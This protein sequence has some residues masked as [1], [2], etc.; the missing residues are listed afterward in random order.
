MTSG[1]CSRTRE[2]DSGASILPQPAPRRCIALSQSSFVLSVFRYARIVV[3]CAFGSFRSSNSWRR[4]PSP[5]VSV[6]GCAFARSAAAAPAL[7][8][9]RSTNCC[10]NFFVALSLCRA[11]SFAQGQSL[12]FCASRRVSCNPTC[13]LLAEPNRGLM[14]CCRRNASYSFPFLF[15]SSPLY[16]HQDSPRSVTLSSNA[17]T[18][19]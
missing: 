3:L 13:R 9:H 14:T 1:H 6:T 10:R 8:G 7:S 4:S 17:S 2:T 5:S 11:N 16:F 19:H 15:P 18:R 12:F